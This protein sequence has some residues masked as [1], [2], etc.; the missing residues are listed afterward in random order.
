MLILWT[1][2]G[3]LSARQMVDFALEKHSVNKGLDPDIAGDG[4]LIGLFIP[5][6]LTVGYFRPRR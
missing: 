1:V 2:V 5:A 6:I 3:I 4:I